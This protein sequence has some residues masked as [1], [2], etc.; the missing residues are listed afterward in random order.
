MT[1]FDKINM[2]K[3][4][5][6]IFFMVY[7]N[8]GERISKQN[9][10]MQIS[11]AGPINLNTITEECDFDKSVKYPYTF[12]ILIANMNHGKEGEGEFELAVYA[13]DPNVTVKPLPFPKDFPN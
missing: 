13:R 4:K 2:F 5:N 10:K 1:Q 7:K 3:G 6:N 11:R 12:T 9:S 8:N